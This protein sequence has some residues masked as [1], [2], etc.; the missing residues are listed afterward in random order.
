M[1]EAYHGY[2]STW[3]ISDSN[4]EV[5]DLIYLSRESLI[6]MVVP[7]AGAGALLAGIVFLAHLFATQFGVSSKNLSPNFAKLKPG[8]RLKNQFQENLLSFAQ[9]AILLPIF[10]YLAYSICRSNLGAIITLPLSQFPSELLTATGILRTLLLNASIVLVGFGV[11]AYM[12]G[13][14][15]HFNQLKM[16]HQEIIDEQREIEGNPLIKSRIKRLQRDFYRR[17]MLRQIPNATAVIVNPTHYAVALRYEMDSRTA[18]VV[19][20]KGRNYL[21][22][23]IREIAEENDVPIVEN[24][25]LA[26]SLYRVTEIGQEIPLE[27]YHA[28]AEV[29]AYVYRILLDRDR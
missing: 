16:S 25:P 2:H 4:L 6:R 9:A 8:P 13:R 14:R 18:P 12:H 22:L 3:C 26:Q 7:L 21:A 15:R 11:L 10:L 28:V 19:V 29:L 1:P 17:G 24:K 23:R 20:A 27:F 5:S